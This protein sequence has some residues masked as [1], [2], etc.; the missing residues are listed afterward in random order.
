[1]LQHFNDIILSIHFKKKKKKEKEGKEKRRKK[2]CSI[3]MTSLCPLILK[4]TKRKKKEIEEKEKKRS[5]H[6]ILMTNKEKIKL[7]V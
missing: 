4:R 1:M 6:F 7:I 2:C 5:I 3:S